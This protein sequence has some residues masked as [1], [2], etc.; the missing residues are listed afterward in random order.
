MGISRE[1]R[2]IIEGEKREMQTG[3]ER[4]GVRE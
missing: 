1:R 2:K 3:F 4:A